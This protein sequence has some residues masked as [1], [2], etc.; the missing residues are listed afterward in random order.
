MKSTMATTKNVK[1]FQAGVDTLVRRHETIPGMMLVFGEP[2]TGKTRTVLWW[3]IQNGAEERQI[4]Y[5]RANRLSSAR[6]ILD[7]IASEL[8]EI[9]SH[10]TAD[11][12]A[13]IKK[14]L[15]ESP[16]PIIIDEVDY[17]CRDGAV[18]ILRDIHDMTKAP[19]IMIGMANADKKLLRFPHFYDRI[20]SIVQFQLLDKADVAEMARQVCEAPLDESAI[21]LI[22]DRSGG[23]LRRIGMLFYQAERIARANDLK[24]VTAEHINKAGRKGEADGGE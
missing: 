6:S 12:M 14:R 18:E 7:E 11:V 4:P 3:K 8:G 10:K 16:R 1:R 23:K 5:V 15:I 20:S 17:L 9:P 2:G 24:K 13:Q 21:S 19:V 22:H